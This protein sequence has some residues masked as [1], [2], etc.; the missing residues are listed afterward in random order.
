MDFQAVDLA[1]T[2]GTNV[3][4]FW[5]YLQDNLSKCQWRSQLARHIRKIVY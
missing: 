4:A 2:F 3:R 1:D 5:S